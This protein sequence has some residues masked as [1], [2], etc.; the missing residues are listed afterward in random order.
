VGERDQHRARRVAPGGDLLLVNL[1]FGRSLRVAHGEVG[2][3][4]QV[5]GRHQVGVHVVVDQRGVLVGSRDGVDP[6]CAAA[7]VVADRAP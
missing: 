2:G 4:T 6:E 3:G 5:P 1:E 7:V